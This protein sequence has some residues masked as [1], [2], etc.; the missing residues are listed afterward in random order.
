MLPRDIYALLA[1]CR[2]GVLFTTKQHPEEDSGLQKQ[3]EEMKKFLLVFVAFFALSILSVQAMAGPDDDTQALI[4]AMKGGNK[5][6]TPA[7]TSTKTK[8]GGGGGAP[9]KKLEDILK[10]L[11]DV[12]K[13]YQEKSVSA[14]EKAARDLVIFYFILTCIFGALS[15]VACI[16]T[17]LR[18]PRAPEITLLGRRIKKLED[19]Q[20]QPQPPPTSPTPPTS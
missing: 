19:S 5:T 3:E 18:L 12:E 1:A 7:V 4:D 16:L 2:L 6:P 11:E 17:L 15:V 9:S 14:A 13:Q 10:R 20:L 8:T